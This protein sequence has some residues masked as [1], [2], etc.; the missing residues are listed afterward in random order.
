M[1]VPLWCCEST[2]QTPFFLTYQLS[3]AANVK[4][5]LS[6]TSSFALAKSKLMG[7]L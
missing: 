4:E 6:L 1:E 5:S 3:N 2:N 7:N